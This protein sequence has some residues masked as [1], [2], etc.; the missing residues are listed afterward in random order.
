MLSV[1]GPCQVFNETYGG[2]DQK[3]DEECVANEEGAGV[4]CSDVECQ[5]VDLVCGSDG[6]TYESECA[7]K[8]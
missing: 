1:A 5:A 6:N 4:C 3:C 2:F 7:L 8:R